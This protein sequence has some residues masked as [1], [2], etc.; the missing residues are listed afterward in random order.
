MELMILMFTDVTG[1][2]GGLVGQLLTML[3]VLLAVL[4]IWAVGRWVGAKLKAP[5][6]ALTGWDILFVL[7]GLVLAV[8]LL[9]T[10]AGH[11]FIHLF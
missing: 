8:N 11:G 5:E 4:L 1:S 10:L 2:G 7:I 9:M 6:V 3:F